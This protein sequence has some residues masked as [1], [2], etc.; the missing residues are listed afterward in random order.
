MFNR[1]K[2]YWSTAILILLVVLTV[3][4]L[5]RGPDLAKNLTKPADKWYTGQVSWFDPWDHNVYFS[6]IGWGKRGGL[7]FPNLYDTQSKK[8]MFVYTA[9]VLIGKLTG[10]LNI[11]NSLSFYSA[12]VFFSFILI[13][14]IWWFL[15]IFFLEKKE[16]ITAFIILIFGGGLGWLFFPQLVLPD[17][18][19]PGFT[20]ESALR[21]PHE[22]ISL[23]LFLL[24]IGLFWRGINQK[25]KKLLILGAA[26]AFLMSFFHPYTLLTLVI[27]FSAWAGLY[28]LKNNNSK[29]IS[30]LIYLGLSGI[31]WF[32]IVGI[33]LIENPG[34]SGLMMQVQKSPGPILAVL[35]WGI[36]FP[37][38]LTGLLSRTNNEKDNFL[39]IW[40]I[41][42]WLIIYLPF[43]FQKLLIR[44]LWF[45]VVILAVRGIVWLTKRFR[46]NFVSLAVIVVIFSLPTS[47]YMTFRR[48]GESQ[49]NRWVYLSAAEGEI[50]ND[51]RLKGRDEEGV[52]AS[53]RIANLIPANT[54]KRVWTGHEFQTPDFNH[55]IL[56][57]NKFFGNEMTDTEAWIF[58]K[59]INTSWIFF[60][61]DERNLSRGK[62]LKYKFLIP[63]IRKDNVI[64]YRI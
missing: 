6:A 57:V 9:Y 17:I 21:R 32:L 55:R 34:F 49:E 15:G 11:S 27:I 14:V 51:L 59:K 29:Y 47:F 22:A 1:V 56:E 33:D 46:L 13:I 44:G 63:V 23:S 37:F 3:N 50:I 41:F 60:G 28:W 40:L 12:A 45:P 35:G 52:L 4:L 16:K 5:N 61:L 10:F 20:L 24:A 36:M 19:Q 26:S 64:L 48:F 2:L 42:G 58:L 8:P 7:A 38:A 30:V 31:V 53:Y 54:T 43:G 39:K 18:G 62:D 25:K